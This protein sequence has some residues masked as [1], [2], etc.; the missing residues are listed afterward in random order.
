MAKILVCEDDAAVLK[1][2]TSILAKA[3]H[4]V[5]ACASGL[6]TLKELGIQ[7]DDPS[8]ELPDLIVLDIMMPRIDGYAVATIMRNSARTRAIPILVVSAL[9]DLRTSFS[10]TESVDG[11]MT[12]PFTKE[13]LIDNVAKLLD[14][15]KARA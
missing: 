5:V 4:K 10:D 7:P 15:R 12:K 11:F 2:E 3:G 13:G 14:P 9:S 1:F 6:E 8:A